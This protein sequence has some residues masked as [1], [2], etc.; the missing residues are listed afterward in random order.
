MI[1]LKITVPDTI[2]LKQSNTN[3]FHKVLFI[4]NYKQ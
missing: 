4:Y 1:N 3:W 2:S